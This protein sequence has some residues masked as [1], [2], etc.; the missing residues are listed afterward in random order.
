MTLWETFIDSYQPSYV[1]WKI[2]ERGTCKLL[3]AD[4]GSL[5]SEDETLDNMEV[6]SAEA[7]YTKK[8]V[9]YVKVIVNTK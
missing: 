1:K 7:K 9:K 6:Y 2:Y 4:Y 8:N 5:K 3:C